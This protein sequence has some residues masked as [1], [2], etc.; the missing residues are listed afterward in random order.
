[1]A[2]GSLTAMFATFFGATVC[3]NGQLTSGTVVLEIGLYQD[4][5]LG[6]VL[7]STVFFICCLW[8]VL[9]E[10]GSLRSV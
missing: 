10:S 1:M 7:E 3:F 5:D 6:P 4:E 8:V 2:C 9:W